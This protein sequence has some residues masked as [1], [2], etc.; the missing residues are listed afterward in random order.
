MSEEN[1]ELVRR[2]YQTWNE[3]GL[4]AALVEFID[5]DV[6]LHDPVEMP[7]GS[8]YRGHEGA[9]AMW[10]HW[11]EVWEEVRF[12]PDEAVDLDDEHVLLRVRALGRVKESDAPVEVSFYEVWTI[13]EQG[14]KAGCLDG[15][16]L[17]PRSRRAVGEGDVGGECRD[18]APSVGRLGNREFGG[19]DP[20]ARRGGGDL[21]CA[22]V[23][24]HG[25]IS[26]A[27][28]VRQWAAEQWEVLSGLHHEI[29]EITEAPDGET[30]VSVQ[31]TQG[32]MRHTDMKTNVQWATT[33]TI[34][35]GK[36]LRAYGYLTR[37]EALE[38]AGLRE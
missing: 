11:T 34:R 29:E 31:R 21:E 1:V 38:A 35:D 3:N 22:R 37:A 23:P 32:R 36:V 14:D 7:D 4:E 10:A 16:N 17:G 12:E 8:V 24:G 13:R 15:P 19:L 9:R 18:R 26:R 6:E 2:G 30:L 25:P 27:R 33:W 28:W 20:S 5:P